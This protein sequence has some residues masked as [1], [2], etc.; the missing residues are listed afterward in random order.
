MKSISILTA[1]LISALFSF[2][3]V[4]YEVLKDR[5]GG[6]LLKGIITLDQIANDT[7]FSWY[8][9]NQVGYVPHTGALETLKKDQ[10]FH[11]IAFIGTWCGDSKN[12]MP[13]FFSLL[14][15]ASYPLEK[16][17]LIATD[18]SKKTIGNLAE[19][20]GLVN[21]PTIIVMKDGKELGRVI[22]YGKYGLFD[23]ELAEILKTAATPVP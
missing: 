20:M 18:R 1:L 5:N 23:M 6:K 3:Q 13:K 4:Q 11:F 19:A 16:V 2:S 12:V 7:A 17:S 15:A 8:A 10:N 9:E 21:V 14:Q 22:E